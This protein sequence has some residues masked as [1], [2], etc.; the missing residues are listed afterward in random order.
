V[1]ASGNS[2]CACPLDAVSYAAKAGFMTTTT[3][4][5]VQAFSS[6]KGGHLKANAPV[7]CRSADGARRT[8]ERLS[9]SNLGVVAFSVA[10]DPE[11]GDYDDQPTV[12]FRAGQL[13]PEFD[14]MP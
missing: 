4:F 5:L 2:C 11:T 7:A 14:A 12:F 10:S 1:I 8:A 13:P 9:L 3:T 6:G